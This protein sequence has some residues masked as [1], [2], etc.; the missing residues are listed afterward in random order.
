M[1]KK[2][3]KRLLSWVM[4]AAM[5]ISMLPI[6]AM[7]TGTDGDVAQ[8]V[9][10]GTYGT[11]DEAVADAADGATIELLADATTKGWQ[12]SKNLTIKAAEGLTQK[13]KITFDTEGLALW[14]VALEF[15]NID[16]VMN[17]IGATPY[18][19]W[20][21]MAICASKDAS[22]TLDNV[23]MT[24]DATGA[25]GSP[26]AIYFCQNNVLNVLNGSNLTIKNYAND[27]LEWDGGN[28]GYNV[29][30]TDSTF[31]SD[32][33]RSGFT[34]TFYATIT[35]SDVDVINSTGNGSNGSHFD[36][37]NSTVDFSNNG[38]HGLSAGNLS[39]KDSTITANDNGMC[40]VIFT[41]TG[42][43]VNS[44]IIITGSKGVSYWNA[45]MRLY[46]NNNSSPTAS[47]DKDTKLTITDN[48]VTGLFLDSGSQLTIEDGA[49][50][51]ITRNRAEQAN[52]TTEKDAAK[53]GGGV[54][55][56]SGASAT[57]P[58]S[59]EIYN[60]HA[61]LAGDDVFVEDTGTISLMATGADWVLDDCNHYID[62][63]YDDA[64][65]TRWDADDAASHV[66]KVDPTTFVGVTALKAA[67]GKDPVDKTSYPSLDKQVSDKNEGW[68]ND[69][70][71]A[72]AGQDVNFKLT[73]NVP[74]D[75]LNYIIPDVDEPEIVTPAAANALVPVKQRGEYHLTFH[76]K[77]NEMLVDATEPVV[78]LDR[79]GDESDV[80]LSL[81]ENEYTY[82]ADPDDGCDFHI[83]IDLVA[84]YNAGIIKEAD[85][86]AAT[87]IVV[88]Y[89]AKLSDDATAGTYENEAWTTVDENEWISDHDK[90]YVN[91][92][93]LS[94]FKYDQANPE[95]GLEGAKFELYQK[96][97]EG[98]VVEG[99]VVELT[100]DANGNIMVD[101]M[102][103]GTYY[104]KETKAPEGYVCSDKELE[105]VIAEDAAN[106]LN[107]A[108][109]VNFAN[110]QIPHTGGMGTTLFSIVGGALIATAGVIFVISRKK[111]ARSAA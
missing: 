57:I 13:P 9:G 91:T 100:S 83:V 22:L 88:T 73:S 76:D 84:L 67:H 64:E 75:L 60:N 105:I 106:V 81:E 37:T 93:K 80:T 94:I 74:D 25:S 38:S 23:N 11:L 36:I 108:I 87:P 50:V 46:N 39:V 17:G 8:I 89:N 33:N 29:N 101:G 6:S 98:N 68:N 72:A 24:M 52:C 107:F 99:S 102:D 58:A 56:R 45:G 7:A 30:I 104:L 85:I 62:G 28:G 35:N 103:A 44:D 40:G 97:N 59:A 92:Y 65:G 69:D 95:K 42:T 32:H 10:G 16:V 79:V 96:D 14:G 5:V 31:V 110:S 48:E 111:R 18:G 78:T 15:E 66:V 41:R 109:S 61:A 90:V 51:L 43:F 4:A 1:K 54:M 49:Q 71:D 3:T 53:K 2:F 26:H 77:M 19:E 20:K 27:A 63:W 82:I 55:V 34:G 70:V 86:E 12:Q 47:V 21:W